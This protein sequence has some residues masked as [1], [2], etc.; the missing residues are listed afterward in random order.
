MDIHSK[1]AKES[2]PAPK[3]AKRKGEAAEGGGKKRPKKEMD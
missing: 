3:K 1:L 2:S